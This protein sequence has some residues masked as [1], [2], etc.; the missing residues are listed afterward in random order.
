M[1]G[2]ISSRLLRLGMNWW[3]PFVG[4]GIRVRE[5]APDFRRVRVDMPLR[6]RNRSRAGTHFGGSLFAMADPFFALMVERNLPDDYLVWDKGAS[7]DFVA[8]GRGRVHAEFTLA[9]RDLDTILAMTAAGDKH[10]HLFRADIRDAED[11]VIARIEK[12]VYVRRW[13][14]PG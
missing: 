13:R 10:L 5:I 8:P 14:A 12:I 1:A 2:K 7:I 9:Q 4:A 11:L 6:L 3:P